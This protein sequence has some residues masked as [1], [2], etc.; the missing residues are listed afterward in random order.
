MASTAATYPSSIV[1]DSTVGTG[2]WSSPSNAGSD[3]NVYTS[4]TQNTQSHYL[5]ATGFGFSVPAGTVDGVV[6]EIGR[7]ASNDGVQNVKDTILKLIKGGAVAG[8][9]KAATATKWPPSEATA[10]YGG[11]SDGWNASLTVSDVN[12]SN[13]GLALSATSVG[14]AVGYVDFVRLTIYYT[15]SGGSSLQTRKLLLGVGI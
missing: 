12:A 10:S 11:A 9:S 3:N 15:G 1:D 14:T 5:W 2:T 13:F 8:D 7:Y 6:V 4:F